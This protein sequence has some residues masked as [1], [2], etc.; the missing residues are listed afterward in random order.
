LKT[1]TTGKVK[2][3]NQRASSRKHLIRLNQKDTMRS[4]HKWAI[5]GGI[6]GSAVD[7]DTSVIAVAQR[8]SGLGVRKE[9]KNPTTG[10]SSLNKVLGSNDPG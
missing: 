7:E 9:L 6:G 5:S 4:T 3:A 10:R 2:L 1:G 8:A